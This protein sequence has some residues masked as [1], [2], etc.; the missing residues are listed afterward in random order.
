M[1]LEKQLKA[2]RQEARQLRVALEAKLKESLANKKV[3]VL[4]NVARKM[5]WVWQR[6]LACIGNSAHVCL[7]PTYL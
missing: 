4:G 3:G 2:S 1:A 7:D 5:S 6:Q